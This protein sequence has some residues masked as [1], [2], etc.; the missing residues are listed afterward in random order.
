MEGLRK[1]FDG[2]QP[3]DSGS[4]S[5]TSLTGRSISYIFVYPV[6]ILPVCPF[7]LPSSFDGGFDKT[8]CRLKRA[9]RPKN[10]RDNNLQLERRGHHFFVSVNSNNKKKNKQA[11]RRTNR[12]GRG[13]RSASGDSAFPDHI[14]WPLRSGWWTFRYITHPTAALTQKY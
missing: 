6:Y 11:S 1:R 4:L 8:K 13:R 3:G 12:Q 9:R 10:E 7:I 5:Q 14:E 2:V